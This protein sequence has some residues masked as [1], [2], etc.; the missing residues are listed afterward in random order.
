[1]NAMGLLVARLDPPLDMEDEFNDWYDREHLSQKLGVPGVLRGRRFVRD[2][3]P[4]Y[5]ACYDLDSLDV[6]QTQAYLATV[7]RNRSEWTTRIM[8]RI[9][10]WDRRIYRQ[11]SPGRDPTSSGHEFAAL[12]SPAPPGDVGGHPNLA[13]RTFVSAGER[14]A[15]VPSLRMLTCDDRA[16]LPMAAGPGEIEVYRTYRRRSGEP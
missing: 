3:Y 6:L 16:L 15:E 5:I 11:T 9:R 1:M 13:V 2:E 12:V 4:R 14:A 10:F 8:S 7:G